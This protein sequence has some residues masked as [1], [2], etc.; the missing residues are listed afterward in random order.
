MTTVPQIFQDAVRTTSNHRKNI[1]VLRKLHLR[2]GHQLDD[3][4]RRCILRILPVKKGNVEAERA[5]KFLTAYLE[6]F[7]S[8]T[9]GQGSLCW[10]LFAVYGSFTAFYAFS[11]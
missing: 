10:T 6:A 4:F 8:G 1:V 3:D 5:I 7:T 9:N 11:S 2:K